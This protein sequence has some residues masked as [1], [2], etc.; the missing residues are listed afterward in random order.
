VSKTTRASISLWHANSHCFL[1]APIS[2]FSST[3]KAFFFFCSATSLMIS[4]STL[5]AVSAAGA[6]SAVATLLVAVR[7]FDTM[8]SYAIW[9]GSKKRFATRHP[10]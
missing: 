5:S 7:P 3:L 9:K 1:K 8:E 6:L 2:S 4:S 10:L